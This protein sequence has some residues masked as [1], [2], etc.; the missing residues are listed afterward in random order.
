MK[1]P[2]RTVEYYS[3]K[4]YREDRD[5]MDKQ[6]L[7]GRVVTMKEEYDET[8]KMAKTIRDD[9]K[10]SPKD[11]MDAAKLLMASLNNSY[12]MIKHGFVT[13]PGNKTEKVKTK[14]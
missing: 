12:N 10:R 5:K 7:Q 13:I 6:S 1:I 2:V 9:P 11:R 3:T 4:I 8:A 14:E